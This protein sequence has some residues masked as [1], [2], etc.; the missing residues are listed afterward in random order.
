MLAMD[1]FKDIAGYTRYAS[2]LEVGIGAALVAWLLVVY[3]ESES[4][5][6]SARPS[7]RSA[8]G[9]SPATRPPGEMAFG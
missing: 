9:R 3:D 6:C 7:A 5:T 1:Q 8:F 4:G 2:R